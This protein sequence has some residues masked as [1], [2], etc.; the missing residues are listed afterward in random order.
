V[1]EG[2]WS[3]PRR[4]PRRLV[5]DGLRNSVDNCL[6]VSNPAQTDSGG[7][8][9]S[10][11]DGIGD[12]C[13]CGDVTG[14]GRV[15]DADLLTCRSRLA[16]PVGLPFSVAGLAKRPIAGGS[17]AAWDLLDVVVTRR[18][19]LGLGPGVAQVCAAALPH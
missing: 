14:E 9:V 7:I 15:D 2:H 12:V 19:L 16:N 10:I 13:Q 17:P 6:Y 3:A 5:A 8:G 18:A 1:D 11:P 4:R